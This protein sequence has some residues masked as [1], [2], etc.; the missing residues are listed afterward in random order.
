MA[1]V[2]ICKL[3]LRRAGAADYEPAG[4]LNTV[5]VPRPGEPFDV[6]TE[7]LETVRARVVHVAAPAP[8]LVGE[9]RIRLDELEFP[10]GAEGQ[11]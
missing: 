11:S 2:K 9:F 5:Q 1:D 3:M 6:R 4:Y 7:D 8:G 10:P